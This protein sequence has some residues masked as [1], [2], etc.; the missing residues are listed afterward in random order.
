MT[1]HELYSFADNSSAERQN[2]PQTVLYS[3]L[4]MLAFCKDNTK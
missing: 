3:L 2:N 4:G 1:A